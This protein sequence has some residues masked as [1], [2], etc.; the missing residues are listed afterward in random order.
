MFFENSHFI[1][2]V[3]ELEERV[4]LIP[5]FDQLSDNE[6]ILKPALTSRFFRLKRR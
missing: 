2:D 4:D 3:V 5:L 1:V 6:Q